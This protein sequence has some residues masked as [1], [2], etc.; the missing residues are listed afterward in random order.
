[1]ESEHGSGSSRDVKSHLEAMVGE[2]DLPMTGDLEATVGEGDL[3]TPGEKSSPP[4]P[5]SS[6]SSSSDS[7]L[8]DFLHLD[9]S[10]HSKSTTGTTGSPQPD[11]DAQLNS[12]YVEGYKYVVED[13]PSDSSL[14]S[15][16]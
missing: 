15:G 6:S 3:P 12:E 2:G 4:S 8:E 11:Q 9:T 13:I 10:E 5:T 16:E 7:S 1:M 14:T